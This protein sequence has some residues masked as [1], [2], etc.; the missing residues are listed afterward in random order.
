[1]AKEGPRNVVFKVPSEKKPI[2]SDI[3]LENPTS[4]NKTFKVKCTSAVI[5]RVQPPFGFIKANDTTNIRLW[6]QNTDGIPTDGKKHY[7]AIY[8]MNSQD[9][10]EH[11]SSSTYKIPLFTEIAR[12]LAL[13]GVHRVNA[14]F[15]KE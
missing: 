14:V 9:G 7:F 5:F 8:F 6:F 1:I 11:D 2:W 12:Y 13:T 10:K 3:K 15:E 4:E